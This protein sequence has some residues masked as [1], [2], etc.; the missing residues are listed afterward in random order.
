MIFLAIFFLDKKFIAQQKG[1]T[2]NAII[3]GLLVSVSIKVFYGLNS[4][5]GKWFIYK[6]NYKFKKESINALSLRNYIFN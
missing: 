5:L 1:D 4:V 3:Y 6:E 2:A